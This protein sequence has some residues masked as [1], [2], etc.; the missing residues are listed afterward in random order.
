MKTCL[1][2]SPNGAIHRCERAEVHPRIFLVWTECNKDVPAGKAFNSNEKITCPK[3]RDIIQAQ[4]GG[5]E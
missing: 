2:E 4:S 5:E 1:Y 3:C